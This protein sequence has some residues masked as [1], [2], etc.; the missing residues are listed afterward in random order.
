MES[1]EYYSLP[2]VARLLG[3]SRIYVY[4]KVKRGEIR[5]IKIGRNYA[6]AKTELEVLL[7]SSLSDE[8]KKIIEQGVKKT[9]RDYGE[10]LKMLGNE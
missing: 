3:V 5:A 6:V 10:T 2:E 7:G 9:I 8:A 1:K 4:Q